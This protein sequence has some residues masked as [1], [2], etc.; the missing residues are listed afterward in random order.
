[1]GRQARGAVVVELIKGTKTADEVARRHDLTVAEIEQW[2][3]E[4]LAAGEQRMRSN[5]KTP[6]SVGGRVQG[7]AHQ[8]RR[9]NAGA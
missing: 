9:A 1:M 8:D 4:F 2:R 6:S 7:I 3:D 5:P